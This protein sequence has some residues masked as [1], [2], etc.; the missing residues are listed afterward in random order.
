ML[1]KAFPVNRELRHFIRLEVIEYAQFEQQRR[2]AIF[3]G[4]SVLFI[5]ARIIALLL[6]Y[7][8]ISDTTTRPVNTSRSHTYYIVY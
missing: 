3:Q 6:H 4:M 8:V 5:S 7:S 1:L 2:F